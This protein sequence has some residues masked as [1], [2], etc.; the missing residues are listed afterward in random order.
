MKSGR[1]FL[2][3]DQVDAQALKAILASA[4]KMKRAPLS[5]QPLIG[6]TLALVF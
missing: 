1:D 5:F 6:K 2:E 4:H 3:L